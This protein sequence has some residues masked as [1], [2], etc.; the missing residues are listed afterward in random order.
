MKFYK[1]IVK[2][3]QYFLKNMQKYFQISLKKDAQITLGF[4]WPYAR[5]KENNFYFLF[6]KTLFDKNLFFLI[7]KLP[8]INLMSVCQTHP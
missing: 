4:L 3:K 2:S 7:I 1:L 8:K 5:K 6:F